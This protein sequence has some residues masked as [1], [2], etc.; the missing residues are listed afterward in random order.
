MYG[1]CT[2]IR[3][4]E[5][6]IIRAISYLLLVTISLISPTIR[7]EYTKTAWIAVKT[8]MYLVLLANMGPHLNYGKAQRLYCRII[9]KLK[10]SYF[11]FL[12]CTQIV[13]YLA[14][15]QKQLTSKTYIETGAKF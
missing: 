14:I 15:L 5:K 3:N 6:T 1:Q 2:L 13:D 7:I 11:A 8:A 12:D 10:G 9:S 4:V